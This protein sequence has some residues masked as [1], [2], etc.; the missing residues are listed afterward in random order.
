MHLALTLKDSTPSMYDEWRML[1]VGLASYSGPPRKNSVS[2]IT[3]SDSHSAL[4]FIS[5]SELVIMT[6]DWDLVRSSTARLLGCAGV[7]GASGRG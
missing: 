7:T 4:D 6:R 2:A 3:N 1:L 5:E